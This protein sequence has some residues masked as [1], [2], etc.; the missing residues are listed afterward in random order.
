MT[1]NSTQRTPPRTSPSAAVR[2]KDK[3]SE[4]LRLD[5]GAADLSCENSNRRGRCTRGRL[6]TML[7]TRPYPRDAHAGSRLPLG[8]VLNSSPCPQR[9]TAGA[10]S[11]SRAESCATQV[12]KADSGT[13]S[14]QFANAPEPRRRLGAAASFGSVSTE[15]AQFGHVLDLRG[16]DLR[17]PGGQSLRRGSYTFWGRRRGVQTGP[18]AGR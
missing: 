13:S 9:A 2:M 3:R 7:T 8:Q 11:E 17:R 14:S 16:V 6:P 15:R 12:K 18:G 10:P 5:N 1:A 4:L